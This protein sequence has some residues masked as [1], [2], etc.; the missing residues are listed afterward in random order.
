MHDK[1]NN[2]LPFPSCSYIYDK[3]GIEA[4]RR[5]YQPFSCLFLFCFFF[6]YVRQQR[7]TLA[8][9]KV[10]VITIEGKAPSFLL[11]ACENPPYSL[12]AV[13]LVLPPVV[14]IIFL[15]Y[16]LSYVEE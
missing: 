9:R 1:R 4:K 10:K 11:F 16:C 14:S 7:H 5:I 8:I 13:F 12:G 2:M 15:V 6:V 3:E